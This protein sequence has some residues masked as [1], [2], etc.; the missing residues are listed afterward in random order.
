MGL[1][2]CIIFYANWSNYLKLWGLVHVFGLDTVI[3]IWS[4]LIRYNLKHECWVYGYSKNLRLLPICIL[5]TYVGYDGSCSNA[6][7]YTLSLQF[8]EGRVSSTSLHFQCLAQACVALRLQCFEVIVSFK[9][10]HFWLLIPPKWASTKFSSKGSFELLEIVPLSLIMCSHSFFHI[11]S[12]LA[13]QIL[14]HIRF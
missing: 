7:L 9:F 11:S 8:V 10:L 5:H 12:I 6:N 2:S 14:Q 4:S 13:T 1:C 3:M